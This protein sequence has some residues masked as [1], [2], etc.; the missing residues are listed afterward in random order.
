MHGGEQL[1]VP[2]ITGDEVG[3]GHLLAHIG[4]HVPVSVMSVPSGW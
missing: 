2:P 1:R 3:V 4:G